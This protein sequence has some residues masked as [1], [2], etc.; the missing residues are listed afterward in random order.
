MKIPNE[1]T[2]DVPVI[3]HNFTILITRFDYANVYWNMVDLYDAF[4]LMQ[5]FNKTSHETNVVWLDAHPTGPL[6]P[7]WH[8]LFSNVSFLSQ[9]PNL[10]KTNECVLGLLRGNSP[11]VKRTS[12]APQMEAFRNFVLSSLGVPLIHASTCISNYIHVLFI[13]RRDYL[14]NPRNPQQIISRKI[15]NEN[16]LLTQAKLKFSSWSIRGIQLDRLPVTQQISIV[17]QSD[18]LVGMHGAAL[19]FSVFL[20]PGS[21]VIELFPAKDMGHGNWHMQYLAKWSQVNY[22]IWRNKDKSLENRTEKSTYIPSSTMIRLLSEIHST[23][24]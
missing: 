2:L 1:S 9:L 13:W 20:Q 22:L 12:S 17:S 8:K 21:G 24:C 15:S 3:T 14:S 7:L 5:F 16:E 10:T 11:L 19:A 4:L 18:I 6:D 23:M